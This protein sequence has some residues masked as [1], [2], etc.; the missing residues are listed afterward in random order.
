VKPVTT[1]HKGDKQG[2]NQMSNK[3]SISRNTT[4]PQSLNLQAI[5]TCEMLK[6]SSKSRESR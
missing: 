5:L 6:G 1:L 4:H 3:K 2:I